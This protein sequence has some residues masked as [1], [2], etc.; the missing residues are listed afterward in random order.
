M[1]TEQ[2]IAKAREVV[3]RQFGRFGNPHQGIHVGTAIDNHVS[4]MRAL[5]GLCGHCTN[6][7]LTFGGGNGKEE[8]ALGCTEKQFPSAVYENTPIGE[9]AFCRD[10]SK[11]VLK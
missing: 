3:S 2:R 10:H 9:E 11:R 5:E 1:E 4:K 6:L 7:E 8:V